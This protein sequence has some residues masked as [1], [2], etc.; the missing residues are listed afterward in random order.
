MVDVTAIV[1]IG[2]DN[3]SCPEEAAHF[4]MKHLYENLQ[5]RS[6]YIPALDGDK[7]PS[8]DGSCVERDVEVMFEPSDCDGLDAHQIAVML[9]NEL[10]ALGRISEWRI[11]APQ[12]K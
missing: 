5:I 2:G 3:E 12:P 9:L 8:H 10:K 6:W 11:T 1:L 7:M 4:A